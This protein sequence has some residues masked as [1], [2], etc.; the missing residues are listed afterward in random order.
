MEDLNYKQKLVDCYTSISW[1]SQRSDYVGVTRAYWRL[2]HLIKKHKE[3]SESGE[4]DIDL[5]T[6][7]I[8]NV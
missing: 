7:E 2:F 1:H 8:I 3:L 6:N 5:K 4:L